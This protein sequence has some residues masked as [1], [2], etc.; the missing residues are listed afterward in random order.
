M[1]LTCQVCPSCL[2]DVFASDKY[3]TWQNLLILFHVFY[4]LILVS[5][6]LFSSILF[7]PS[8]LPGLHVFGFHGFHI[9][10]SI[11]LSNSHLSEVPWCLFTLLSAVL[12]WQEACM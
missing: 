4:V 9:L 10:S 2:L 1:S 3:K 8:L 12:P 7:V 5:A 6:F 11:V